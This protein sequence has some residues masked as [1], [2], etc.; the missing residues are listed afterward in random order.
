MY[1][2]LVGGR[3]A[4]LGLAGSD[5]TSEAD[6]IVSRTHR[7]PRPHAPTEDELAAHQA[8]L[9]KIKDPVWLA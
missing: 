4:T 3:Q 8:L 2:E 7:T 9:A 1:L 6:M 5:M